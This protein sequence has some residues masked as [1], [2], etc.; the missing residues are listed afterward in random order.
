MQAELNSYW[1][2]FRRTLEMIKFEHSIFA[3]P[4][5]LLAALL[6]ARGWPSGWQIGWIVAA[7]VGARSAAMTF[8]RIVDRDT[9]ARNPRTRM[10]A[11]PAG[12]L[13]LGFA[14]AFFVLAVAIYELAAWELNRLSLE[15]S[16]PALAWLLFYS[17]TKRFTWLSHWVLG[18]ALGLAPAA[19]WIAIRGSLA[20]PILWL[21]GAVAFWVAGFDI[22]YASQDFD[23]DRSQPGLYSLPKRLGLSRALGWARAC[24][25][26]LLILLAVTAAQ[27]HLGR[28][29]WM[30]WAVVAGLLGWEHSLVRK[31]DFSRVNTAFFTVNGY[32]GLL[33][34]VIWGAAIVK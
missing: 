21:S 14:L 18:V 31:N 1:T 22:L 24:H 9:D 29:G 10:R 17:Y 23:F 32:I 26:A 3:L 12:E 27:F 28:L 25:G 19:A 6:A 30:G 11:L 7:M 33:L 8:N 4:F 5:A 34:L 2:K 13:S 16:L 15:L 20:W